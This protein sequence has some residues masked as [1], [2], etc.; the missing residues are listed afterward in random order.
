M[1]DDQEIR[2][3]VESGIRWGHE[4]EAAGIVVTVS[5]GVVTLSGCA[6]KSADKQD[7]ENAARRVSGVAA[8]ANDIEVLLDA[9]DRQADPEIAREAIAI[10]RAELPRA[11]QDVQVI[12]RDGHVT[13]EGAVQWHWQRQRIESMLYEIRGVTAVSNQLGIRPP[14]TPADVKPNRDR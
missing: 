12:V 1:R 5:D 9:A 11:A 13:L 10:L 4:V 2:A 3:E 14:V 7:A 8:V 6:P